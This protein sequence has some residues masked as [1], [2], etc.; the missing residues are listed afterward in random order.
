MQNKEKEKRKTP[1]N[2]LMYIYKHE[3]HRIKRDRE[4][5]ENKKMKVTITHPNELL[6]SQV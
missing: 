2:L 3:V 5:G 1:T 4:I 6:N